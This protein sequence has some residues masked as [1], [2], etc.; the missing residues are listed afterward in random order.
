MHAILRWLDE[1]WD[2]SN[3]IA[4]KE[5]V[6]LFIMEAEGEAPPESTKN[7]FAISPIPGP[8]DRRVSLCCCT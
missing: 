3:P 6:A 1:D 7:T 4:A 5:R 2:C 8:D